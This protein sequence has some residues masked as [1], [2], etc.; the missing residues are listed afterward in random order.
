[1]PSALIVCLT[2]KVRALTHIERR[3]EELRSSAS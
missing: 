2:P 1:M 3:P